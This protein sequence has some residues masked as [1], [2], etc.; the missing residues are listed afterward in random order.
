MDCPF[1]HSDSAEISNAKLFQANP[2]VFTG[3]ITCKKCK[4]SYDGLAI[5]IGKGGE[6]NLSKTWREFK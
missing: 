1:C 2:E 6:S 3:T 4:K 5:G